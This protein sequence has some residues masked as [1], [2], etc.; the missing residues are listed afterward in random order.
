MTTALI[1]LALVCFA[2]VALYRPVWAI[3]AFLFVLPA[4]QIR[5][6]LAGVPTT[7]LELLFAVL[8][9]VWLVGMNRV[10][11]QRVSRVPWRWLLIALLAC[12][13]VSVVASPDKHAALGLFK[14]YFVE[15][16]LFFCILWE[17]I[18]TERDVRILLFALGCSAAV[19]VAAAIVQ[20]SNLVSSPDP[21][22]S[23]APRRVVGVFDYPNALA[24]Y[25]AP[26][27]GLAAAF[28]FVPTGY[29]KSPWEKIFLA[30]VALFSILGV[31]LSV[32][33]GGMIG[34]AAGALFI[35]SISPFRK[36]LWLAIIALSVVLL[37]LPITRTTVVNIATRHDASS[38]VRIVLWQGTR[39][40]LERR[41]LFGAGLGGFPFYYNTYRL[42][43]HTELLLYPHNIVLNFWVE[44][45]IAG[46]VVVFLFFL[47]AFRTGARI[48]R[49]EPTS[50][51]RTLAA[52]A[53]ASL[54]ILIAHG[55][56]DVPFFKNDLALQFFLL[57]SLLPIAVSLQKA[58]R[59]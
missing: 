29:R 48:L 24:L 9:L 14:A 54:V 33:R 3:A 52:A 28:L 8:V 32:S 20:Y 39:Q 35:A 11:F 58:G 36:Q 34:I 5:L 38:D 50:F 4:Y 43:Q 37:M 30:G 47:Q 26:L 17:R 1:I 2:A 10:R 42:P 57:F 18:R 7:F 21:W 59:V 15:P 55:A 6:S 44:I 27:F 45:G 19:A 23:Q 22:N 40:L 16:V 31:L 13:A 12:A 53:L 25:T 41:P 49:R 56:V 51:A 46:L